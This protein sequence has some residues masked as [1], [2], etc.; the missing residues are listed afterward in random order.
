MTL[1]KADISQKIAN[2][3]GFI[4]NE[5]AKVLEKMLTREENLPLDWC[6]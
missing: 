4:K 2:D 5:T 6:Y 3:C 1:S